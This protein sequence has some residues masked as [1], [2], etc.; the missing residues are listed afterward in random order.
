MNKQTETLKLALEALENSRSLEPVDVQW[1]KGKRH[2]AIAAIRDALAEESSGTEQPKLS[3]YEPDGMHH[4]KQHK[5]KYPKCD[6][7]CPDLPDCRDAEQIVEEYD[8][9][10]RTISVYPSEWKAQQEPVAV[11]TV[12][13]LKDRTEIG[14][15]PASA[16]YDLPTGEYKLY[17]SPQPAQQEP[18]AK[19]VTDN[20][21][22]LVVESLTSKYLRKGTKLYTFPP[23]SKPWIGL[24]NE[25]K[26]EIEKI[27]GITEDD[28][29]WMVSQM[30]TLAEA[31]LR[32]KNT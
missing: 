32:E 17:T 13:H 1:V 28:D 3:D 20:S 21:R 15:G 27:V 11:M 10:N 7:P 12:L 9:D 18:V 24:T 16:G 25:D 5:C 19:V 29:G 6:Y 23:A 26:A 2:A 8:P 14:Y 30:F 22:E 31:K 4:N